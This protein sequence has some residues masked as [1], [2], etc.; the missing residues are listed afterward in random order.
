MEE[1][2]LSLSPLPPPHSDHGAIP[3]LVSLIRYHDTRVQITVLGALKNLSFGRTMDDNKHTIAS[4]NNLT[5][6][7]MALKNSRVAEVRE[8]L[9]ALLWNLS[10]C[11]A[12]KLKMMK[13]CL[14]DLVQIVM[15]T[16]TGW[17]TEESR[18]PTARP[19]R[20]TWNAELKN[21]TGEPVHINAVCDL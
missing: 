15:V 19:Q 9:T 10:S 21:T 18:E 8:L 5:E 14:H 12:L 13:A 7:M 20:V 17:N 11:E 16:Y 1:E 3:V 2:S 4:D 6:I